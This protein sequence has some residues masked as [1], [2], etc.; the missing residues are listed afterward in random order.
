MD[1]SRVEPLQYCVLRRNASW[2]VKAK[3]SVLCPNECHKMLEFRMKSS[4]L[5]SPEKFP[6]VASHATS[7]SSRT[8][9]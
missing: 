8:V 6:R 3:R 5:P 2:M 7:S 1:I 4:V 9:N